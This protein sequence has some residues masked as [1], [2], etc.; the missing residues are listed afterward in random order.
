MIKKFKLKQRVSET[1][2]ISIL[3]LNPEE[4]ISVKLAK[5]NYTTDN[6]VTEIVPHLNVT[7]NQHATGKY[8]LNKCKNNL[9]G[10][11]SKMSLMSIWYYHRDKLQ[12]N[13]YH[14]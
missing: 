6:T 13:L 9:V 10:L 3:L 4:S 1:L 7:K 5:S 2:P 14:T 12:C 8:G 11:F